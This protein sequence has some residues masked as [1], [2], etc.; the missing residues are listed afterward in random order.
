M[1]HRRIGALEVSVVGLGGNGFGTEMFG[2][3]ADQAETTRIVDAALDSGIT[4]IDTAEEYSVRSF[5]GDNRSEEV[6]GVA[7]RGRRDRFVIASKF[8]NHSED[9]PDQRGAARIVA[10]VEGSLRRL[11]TDRI[12]LYQQH[13]PDPDTPLD[14]ILGALDRLVRDGKVREIG[15]CNFGATMLDAAADVAAGRGLAPYRSNQVQLSVLEPASPDLVATM[16]RRGIPA[17]AYFPLAHGLLTG[18]YR[19]GS[20]PPSDARLGTD[21]MVSTMFRDGMMATRPPLSDA[22]LTTVERL[23][24]FAAERGHTVLELA[25]SWLVAQPVVGSVLTGVTKATQVRQNAAAADWAMTP[26][27]VIAVRAIVAAEGTDDGDGTGSPGG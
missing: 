7:L 16:A 20:P 21:T 6:L 3:A 23:T 13:F 22:R 1:E 25:V 9:D 24:A 4:L 19:R 27:D 18:K 2:T 15:C 10:A 14:E 11:D 26:E 17:L 5:L 8:Q 12:D